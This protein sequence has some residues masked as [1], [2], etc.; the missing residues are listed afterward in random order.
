MA[1]EHTGASTRTSRVISARPEA[2]Y[3]AFIEAETIKF[4]GI[5]D[6]EGLQIEVK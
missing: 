3:Q 5:I 2:L 4:K 1:E 6:K